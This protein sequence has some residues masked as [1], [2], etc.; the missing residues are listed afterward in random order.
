MEYIELDRRIGTEVAAE[1]VDRGILDMPYGPEIDSM[2]TAVLEEEPQGRELHLRDLIAIS[3]GD[4]WLPTDEFRAFMG[5]ATV[6]GRIHKVGSG[7][8]YIGTNPPESKMT[9][10]RVKSKVEQP[11]EVAEPILTTET[12]VYKD[13]LEDMLRALRRVA[14]NGRRPHSRRRIHHKRQAYM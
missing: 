13:S 8:Y 14:P 5:T 4:N 6:D 11:Q 3:I 9:E 2:I 12:I 7:F 10:E 1:Q